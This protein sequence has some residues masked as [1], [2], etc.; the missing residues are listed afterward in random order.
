[1]I[2]LTPNLISNDL[3]SI[4][5]DLVNIRG[6]LT[7]KL[8]LGDGFDPGGNNLCDPDDTFKMIGYYLNSLGNEIINPAYAI[9]RYIPV[10]PETSYYIETSTSNNVYHAWYNKAGQLLLPFINVSG[11]FNVTSSPEA[12]YLRVTLNINLEH[13]IVSEGSL[14]INY[15]PYIKKKDILNAISENKTVINKMN[16]FV[17]VELADSADTYV[18]LQRTLNNDNVSFYDLLRFTSGKAIT[19]GGDYITL[20]GN[21]ATE[22]F[23]KFSSDITITVGP[24][25]N[26]VCYFYN[27][28]KIKEYSQTIIQNKT[29]TVPSS[30]YEY[31]RFTIT[32]ES[33]ETAPITMTIDMNGKVFASIDELTDKIKHGMKVSSIGN[34][35]TELHEG[36][37][38]KNGNISGGNYYYTNKIRV[39]A[40]ESLSFWSE[41]S[42]KIINM[43]CRF[44]CAY[45]INGNTVVEKGIEYVTAYNVPDGVYEIV[46][47]FSNTKINPMIVFGVNKPSQYTTTKKDLYIAGG[48]FANTQAKNWL[49]EQRN[50]NE[51]KEGILYYLDQ[52][53]AVCYCKPQNTSSSKINIYFNGN[54]STTGSSACFVDFTNNT[55]GSYKKYGIYNS[56]SLIV[57]VSETVGFAFNINHDYCIEYNRNSISPGFT[58]KITD[59][60]TL[61]S[62]TINLTATANGWGMIGYDATDVTLIGFKR[63]T[64]LPKNPSILILGDSYTEG[65]TIWENRDKR[66]CYLLGEAVGSFAINAQGGAR[67]DLIE[68]WIDDYLFDVFNPKY[69]IVETGTNEQAFAYF[70]RNLTSIIAKIK[71]IGAKPIL[72][73]VPVT[74]TKSDPSDYNDFVLNSGLPYIDICRA[75]TTNGDRTTQNLNYF[76]ADNIHPN[77]EGHQR[78]FEMAKLNV[79]ELFRDITI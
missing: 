25:I 40:G 52:K 33:Y 49:Q 47:S 8:Y 75:L 70:T 38:A 50:N 72:C 67:S 79:P 46:I 37:I 14:P 51:L 42:N 60:M 11:G 26:I 17:G 16:G 7:S 20:S 78:I 76:L 35:I 74:T 28:S 71:A 24:G 59:M 3:D 27:V 23:M 48:D 29:V 54:E 34:Q 4:G 65:A 73:T 12:K 18:F 64:N 39:E 69:V 9:S 32:T 66:W 57:D 15:E 77:I 10:K 62:D 5:D 41:S 68:S 31:T 22:A 21:S 2:R 44:V 56:S 45:D 43:Q 30:N 36:F 58:L 61:E 63:L 19:S 55:F 13:P 53:T 1:M 6:D